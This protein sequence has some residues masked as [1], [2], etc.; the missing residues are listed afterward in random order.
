MK[1]V[2]HTNKK[3]KAMTSQDT[4]PSLLQRVGK[5]YKLLEQAFPEHRSKQN[6]L[7]IPLLADD[8]GYAHETLYRC[9]RRDRIK[10][11][12]ALKILEFS[13]KTQPPSNRIYWHDLA[14]FVLPDFEKY[15]DPLDI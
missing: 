13:H 15:S 5:L 3:G 2:E 6:V 1:G 14:P 4:R 8:L 11:A 9:V 12:V 10:T 7:A